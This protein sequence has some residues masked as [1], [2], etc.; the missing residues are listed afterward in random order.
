MGEQFDGLDIGVGIDNT[1]VITERAS[2]CK[3]ETFPS[4][5]T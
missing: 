3:A 4:F 2:A 1:S 5:G